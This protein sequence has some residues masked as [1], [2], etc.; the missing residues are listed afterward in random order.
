M[1]YFDRHTNDS[2]SCKTNPAL[3]ASPADEVERILQSQGKKFIDNTADRT[4]HM[5]ST[6]T[7]LLY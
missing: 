2:L 7:H 6:N 3:G 5:Y 1:G 4:I